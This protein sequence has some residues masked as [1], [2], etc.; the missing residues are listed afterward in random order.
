MFLVSNEIM[1]SAVFRELYF[2]FALIHPRTVWVVPDQQTS[3]S[4]PYSWS[5]EANEA[6]FVPV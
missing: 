4:A 1:Y 6:N 5:G 3:A 2:G